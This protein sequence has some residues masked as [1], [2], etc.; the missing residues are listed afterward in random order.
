MIKSWYNFSQH[1]SI[2]DQS[3][4]LRQRT[5]PT[6]NKIGALY[7]LQGNRASAVNISFLVSI[8]TLG[9]VGVGVG[10]QESLE[11]R[12]MLILPGTQ[13]FQ[14]TPLPTNW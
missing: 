14:L 11:E 12:A 1:L 10:V 2:R 13:P 8:R 5:D 9:G 6:S 7:F 4:L 3:P